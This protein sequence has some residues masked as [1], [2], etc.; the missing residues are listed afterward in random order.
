MIE[1]LKLRCLKS[2]STGRKPQYAGI[3]D[4]CS[5]PTLAALGEQRDESINSFESDGSLPWSV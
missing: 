5:T 4:K 1:T 2:V 3:S